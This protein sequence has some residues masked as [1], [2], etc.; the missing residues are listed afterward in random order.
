MIKEDVYREIC[1]IVGWE[2]DVDMCADFMGSN[3]HT[4]LYYDASVDST[5]QDEWLAGA[6][7][8]GNP[9]FSDPTPFI[10]VLERAFARNKKTRALLLVPIRKKWDWWKKLEASPHW[11]LRAK[12]IEGERMY[13][14]P[15]KSDW[16]STTKREEG[17]KGTEKYAIWE[18]AEHR[19]IHTEIKYK[20][21][22]FQEGE[23]IKNL[24]ILHILNTHRE[25][26]VQ[27]KM[28]KDLVIL[29]KTEETK[30]SVYQCLKCFK[31]MTKAGWKKHRENCNTLSVC[32]ECE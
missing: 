30:A 7:V 3:V 15:L 23:Q 13:T 2:A 8:W 32:P 18:L 9:P 10:E 6:K 29:P 28:A 16:F 1:D 25:G 14:R 31:S 19:N 12:Y 11:W 5:Q 27:F 21:T 22:Q 20:D 26:T 17:F 4:P 24:H